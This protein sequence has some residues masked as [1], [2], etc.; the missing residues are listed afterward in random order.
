[1]EKSMG[2][3]MDFSRLQEACHLSNEARIISKKCNELRFTSP[4][5]MRGSQAVYFS[6][7]FSQ[8]WGKKDFVEL[9]QL[10]YN[11][12][13]EAKERVEKELTIDDTHRLIWLHL[14]PFYSGDLLNYVETTCRAPIVFEEVNFIGWEPLDLK[15][16]YRSLARK[17]MTVGFLDPQARVDYIVKQAVKAK[18]NGCILYNHMFGRCSMA[19]TSFQKHLREELKKQSV[20]LL[21]L[22]GDCVDP[23]IDP[24]STKTKISSY[25][26]ALN[27]KKYGNIFG[28]LA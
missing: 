12:L 23:T 1:M 21:V 22:D 6:S 7:I 4:P 19:D 28:P 16:P 5:L 17:L 9:Q 20:P 26:E 27:E 24:C 18:F 25:I 2:L 13:L 3:K 11:D 8:L 15:D 10:Y 14:P